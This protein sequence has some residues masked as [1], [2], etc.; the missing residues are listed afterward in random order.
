MIV[1]TR[2]VAKA[3]I[4]T[5]FATMILVLAFFVI[6]LTAMCIGYIPFA[7]PP[8]ILVVAEV[9]AMLLG[10]VGGTL[11]VFTGDA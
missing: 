11:L 2:I 7:R 1:P 3:L 6:T 10:M 8:M 9:W 4:A 5:S